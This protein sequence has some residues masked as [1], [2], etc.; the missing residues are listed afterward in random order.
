MAGRIP[1]EFIDQLLSR[2]DIVDVIDKRV[3]LKKAGKELQ[4][5]CPFHNEKTPSFTV[6]PQ[7]Q[8]YHCFG[9]GAHGTAVGFLMEYDRLSFPEAVEELA[10]QAGLEVPHEEGHQGP[11]H[12]P[13][14]EALAKS[15]AFYRQQ[16]RQHPEAARAVAYLK[17]RGMSGEIAAEYGIGFA[18]PGWDNLLKQLGGNEQAISR[19]RT[20]GMITEGDGK[21]YDRFRDRIMFPIRDRRGRAIAFGGRQIG[22]GKPK[23]LNS[24]ETPVFHKGRELYGL[25]EARQALKDIQRLVVVEGYMDVVALA[26]FG[27]RN[28]VATLGTA[29]T[30]DHLETLFRT[31]P[32]VVFCFD[33]DRAGRAAA[34]K[35]L[36]TSLPVL[37]EGREARFLFLPE[38]DDPDTLVRR[39][40]QSAFNQLVGDALPLSRFLFDALSEQVD[41]DSID[42]RARL[43]ELAKPYLAK[44]PPG[45]FREMMNKHLAELVGVEELGLEGSGRASRPS[46]QQT[47]SRRTRTGLN[48]IPPLRRAIALLLHHPEIA[49]ETTLPTG[50]ESLSSPGIPLFRA[51]V[52]FIHDRSA[53]TLASILEHWRNSDDAGHLDKI[54]QLNLDVLEEDVA[55]QLEGAVNRVLEDALNRESDQLLEKSRH[56]TLTTEEKQRLRDL[57]T[58]RS[59]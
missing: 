4:A 53:P 13:L 16:L 10:R 32:E 47:P 7:K 25:Y 58:H 52:A 5:C 37:R 21:R 36:E 19:L 26:Q 48:T 51:L 40:G 3:P 1:P 35:A 29:T 57:L 27:I 44:L 31:T 6:S 12:R 41:M 11:D 54:A 42:G 18:P 49:K 46:R 33:G 55:S 8:F 45:L 22:D 34:W 59:A 56:T 17:N 20:T 23:Y 9:C 2:I 38:G 50:W 15:A 14:Y 30:P 24:P 43:A 28:T 39:E